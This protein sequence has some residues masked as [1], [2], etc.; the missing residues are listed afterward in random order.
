MRDEGWAPIRGL[1]A[2]LD[3]AA[4]KDSRFFKGAEEGH[5][6]LEPVELPKEK[7][8]S[9]DEWSSGSNLIDNEPPVESEDGAEVVDDVG[10]RDVEEI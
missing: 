3:E 4:E 7:S 9:K 6:V 5:W 1:G 8:L 10:L 2:L